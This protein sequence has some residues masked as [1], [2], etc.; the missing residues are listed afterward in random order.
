M[1]GSQGPI[2]KICIDRL[3]FELAMVRYDVLLI[4]WHWS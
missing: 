3:S 1:D 4:L 2:C